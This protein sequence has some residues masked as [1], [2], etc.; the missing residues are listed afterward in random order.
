MKPRSSGFARVIWLSF[1]SVMT[2]MATSVPAAA[3]FLAIKA[4]K[5]SGST[6]VIE[7]HGFRKDVGRVGQRESSSRSCRLIATEIKAALPPLAP[8]TYRLAIRQGRDEVAR[9]VVT[10][11][12]GTASQGPAGPAGPTG[13]AGPAGAMGPRGLQGLQGLQG[14]QGIQGPKGDK[15]DTGPAGPAGTGAGAPVV[16]A[17]NGQVLGSVAGVTKFSRIRSGDR[18]SQ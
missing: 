14:I 1:V 7:G 18:G 12:G 6:L 17:A 13:P 8:G 2:L 9:F 16:V 5:P 4:A 11:G 3:D 15:G 10:V